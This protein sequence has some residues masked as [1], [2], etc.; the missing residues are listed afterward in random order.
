MSQPT[1]KHVV[2]AL[3]LGTVLVSLDASALNVALPS[4]Q[5]DLDATSA[6]L[7]LIVVA[8]MIAMAACILPIGAIS[9]RVGR[10]VIYITGLVGF[11]IGSA[12]SAISWNVEIL[13]V[14]RVIQGF[15]GAAI[16]GLSVAILTGN[17]DRA[18]VPKIIATWTTVSIV[19]GSSGPFVG[20]LLVSTFGWRSVYYINIP[21]TILVTIVSLVSLKNDHE[22]QTQR[23]KLTGAALLAL[24]L[25]SFTWAIMHMQ[26]FGFTSLKVLLPLVMAIIVMALFVVEERHTDTPLVDWGSLKRN[27]I[28]VSLVLNLL[29]GL[30]L[31]GSLYQMT[32]F[33]QNVLDFSP[34]LA[35]T[36]TL[37]VSLAIML[38]ASPAAKLMQAAGTALPVTIAM[39]ISAGGMLFLGQLNPSSTL[40]II[41]G[42]L[43]L[44]IGLGVSTPIMSAIAMQSAS[45]S[46]TGA[47]SGSLGLVSLVGSIL[48][49]TVMGGLTSSVAVA[50]WSNSGGDSALDSLV[51]VGNLNEV[52]SEA[53]Q[54][55]RNLAANSYTSGVETTFTV[56][57]VILVVASLCA[58]AFLPKK[59]IKSDVKIQLTVPVL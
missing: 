7:Q 58:L 17:A 59:P 54:A 19:A 46:E 56:G 33:N 51:G 47:V 43:I 55:A 9:D 16:S 11:A 8:Y 34:T 13:I 23:V 27:P 5:R 18:R 29:L 57:A 6:N 53:G 10:K 28:P 21:L 50:K 40:I 2:G 39:L 31:S 1:G 22:V 14:A 42:L 12:L 15:G 25:T 30:A 26:Q 45:K 35:G 37:T 38:L 41:I 24:T 48:G 3:A 49:I 20:G 44:G 52:A 32:L 4:V 36:L